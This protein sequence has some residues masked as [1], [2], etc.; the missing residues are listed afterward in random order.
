MSF[1]LYANNPSRL[2]DRL[3]LDPVPLPEQ[4]T[5]QADDDWLEKIRIMP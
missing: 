1:Q 3:N 5:Y 4:I 2:T